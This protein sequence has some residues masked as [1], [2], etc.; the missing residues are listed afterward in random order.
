ME[1]DQTNWYGNPK[2]NPH[3]VDPG[4]CYSR[5]ETRPQWSRDTPDTAPTWSIALGDNLACDFISEIG[6][7]GKGVL[8]WIR[9]QDLILRNSKHPMW[10]EYGFGVDG[11]GPWSWRCTVTV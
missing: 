4:V 7:G 8:K 9:Q 3:I 2:W 5:T 6:R 1:L 11:S 10:K